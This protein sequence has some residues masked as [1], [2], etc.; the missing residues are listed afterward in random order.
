M[1]ASLSQLYVH[2]VDVDWAGFD[3]DYP[4]HKVSLPTYPFQRKRY[5]VDREI[6]RAGRPGTAQALHPLAERFIESPSLK[7]IV[8]ETSLSAASHRF[9]NDH[10]VFGR[11]IFPA[12]G[13]LESVARCRALGPGRRKLGC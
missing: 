11:I 10:R 8:F 4:R 13:Y 5:F 3:R 9:V 12:T 1:L 7:D 2:G 6:Q